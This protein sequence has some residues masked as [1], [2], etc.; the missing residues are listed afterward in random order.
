MCELVVPIS[1]LMFEARKDETRVGLVH[2]CTFILL[3]L[4]GEREFGV[5]LNKPFRKHLPI[6]LPLFQGGHCD[7][8]V[9]VLHKMV[10]DGCPGLQSL[11]RAP[12]SCTTR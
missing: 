2:I 12:R 8:L 3:K 4:S 11:V 5:Q 10:T 1:Y 7:L 6:Q 9:V